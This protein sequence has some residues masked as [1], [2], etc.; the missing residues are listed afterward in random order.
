MIVLGQ[1]TAKLIIDPD[2]GG[3]GRSWAPAIHAYSQNDSN[4][5][6]VLGFDALVANF[7]TGDRDN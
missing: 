7:H 6:Y 3:S 5:K 4:K 2:C 1:K